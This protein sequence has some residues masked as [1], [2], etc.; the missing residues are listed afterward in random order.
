MVDT[1]YTKSIPMTEWKEKGFRMTQATS[2]LLTLLLIPKTK[3]L[4]RIQMSITGIGLTSSLFIREYESVSISS[5]WSIVY[6]VHQHTSVLGRMNAVSCLLNLGLGI[7]YL[8]E[9]VFLLLLFYRIPLST[10]LHK[11]HSYTT[12]KTLHKIQ[13]HYKRHKTRNTRQDTRKMKK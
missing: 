13:E 10:R 4:H 7:K 1:L 3:S 11:K 9:Y 12:Q 5:A 6:L 2:A 8:V